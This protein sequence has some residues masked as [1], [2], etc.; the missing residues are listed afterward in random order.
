M[1][2]QAGIHFGGKLESQHW[3]SNSNRAYSMLL[4]GPY[5]PSNIAPCT[6]G[7]CVPTHHP[8]DLLLLPAASSL[9]N[10]L[11]TRA[12]LDSPLVP[13]AFGIAYAVLAWQAWQA[14]SLEVVRQVIAAAQPLPDAA[15]FA[16][17]F[18]HKAL[19]ALAWLHLLMLDFLTAR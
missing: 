5:V 11:Q 12:I 4:G 15:T 1:C 9:N 7:D 14:G 19:A 2:S 8:A 18:Q 3:W 16:G 6:N 10:T 17:L 13:L